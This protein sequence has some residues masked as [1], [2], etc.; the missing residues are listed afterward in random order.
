MEAKRIERTGYESVGG[1]REERM[2]IVADCGWLLDIAANRGKLYGRT[3]REHSRKEEL[4]HSVNENAQVQT[5]RRSGQH[6]E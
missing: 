3:T 1:G 5:P 2:D 4:L 6:T